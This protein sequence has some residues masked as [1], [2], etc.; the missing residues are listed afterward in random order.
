MKKMLALLIF[1]LAASED[2]SAYVHATEESN[3]PFTVDMIPSQ[4]QIGKAEYYHVPGKPGETI[5]LQAKLSNNSNQ[6][7]EVKVVPLNAYSSNTGIFY[8][9]PAEVDSSRFSLSD[10][11][12]GLAQY[13]AEVSPITLQPRQSEVVSFSVAVPELNK[14]SL[15][16]SIR[17]VIFE[18][19][20]EVDN[21]ESG[22]KD[23]QLL[24]DKYQA[25][26][27]AIQ[28]DLPES[29]RSLVAF[30]DLSF[31]EDIANLNLEIINQAAIIQENIS[32]T[33]EIL[34]A[35]KRVLFDGTIPSF[36]MAPMSKFQYAIPWNHKTLSPGT[37]TFTLKSFI[38]GKQMKD[39]KTFEITNQS[40]ANVKEKQAE[41]NP[42]I[43][44]ERTALPV[45]I[46]VIMAVLIATIVF[47]FVMMRKKTRIEGNPSY[48][49]VSIG[50]ER[51]RHHSRADKYKEPNR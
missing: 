10:E 29:D 28:I 39:A 5:K 32:G 6:P 44:L 12:Y 21:A 25:I 50:D 18:G 11:K 9:S 27:T 20:T 22:Q 13:M 24:I 8:Q 34:D 16:G 43:V 7:L 45:W 2:F 49:R 46:W 51:Q 37:Y 31:N 40:A 3:F 26:D 15:L 17:F 38:D 42:N 30:G 23:S 36:K 1:L 4:N 19:T 14:G 41:V 47:L 48:E 35:N 33:Y